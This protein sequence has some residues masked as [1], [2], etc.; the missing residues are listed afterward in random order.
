MIVRVGIDDDGRSALCDGHCGERPQKRAGVAASERVR[1][2]DEGINGF[3]PFGQTHQMRLRPR[4]GPGT[5]RW[6]RQRHAASEQRN[7][8][9][10]LRP[11][12]LPV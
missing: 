12:V 5:F 1:L 10:L 3:G 2:A 9:R 8:L 7:A 11:T 4:S 6:R